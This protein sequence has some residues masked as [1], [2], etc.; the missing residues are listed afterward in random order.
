MNS[1]TRL[2]I[3]ADD[4]GADEA[5]NDA[6]TL[7]HGHGTLSCASMMMGQ[8]ATADAIER[9]H[10]MPTLGVGLHLTLVCGVPVLPPAEVSALLG[11]DGRLLENLPRAGLRWALLSRAK[12]QLR[13][14]IDAQFEAFAAT[15]LP[16]DH[17]N[18]HNHMHLH[19]LVLDAIIERAER[20]GARWVR[21]P[22]EPD[23]LP[24]IARPW[25]GWMRWRLK[26]AG[27]R[28]NDH[29]FGLQLSGHLAAADLVRA[30]RQLKPGITELY[31]HPATRQNA[32]I[33]SQMPGYDPV[34][35]FAALMSPAFRTALR[36]LGLVPQPF[37][38]LDLI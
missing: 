4:F 26:R 28:C 20:H 15:G 14:E 18:A 24:V 16:L 25:L 17:V 7:A 35:E 27:L 34:G 6:V 9:A 8:R 37:A 13:R 19:P 29:L 5:I 30:V 1:S 2:V 33:Q 12:A 11:R 38:G 21:L 31:L 36:E 23:G 10:S 3:T 32:H 22:N